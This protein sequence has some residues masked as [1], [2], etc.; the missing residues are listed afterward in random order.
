[1]LEAAR[2]Y[3]Q[4]MELG[5]VGHADDAEGLSAFYVH[6]QPGASFGD[7]GPLTQ[8]LLRAGDSK[9]CPCLAATCSK[10]SHSKARPAYACTF[11]LKVRHDVP[12]AY[13]A[14]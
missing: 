9:V 10:A 14:G 8:A 4:V 7:A 13:H 3:M 11:P 12:V 5:Q 1:M 2:P 6:S